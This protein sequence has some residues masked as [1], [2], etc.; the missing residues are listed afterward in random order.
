MNTSY[1][2]GGV[3]VSVINSTGLSVLLHLWA[4]S[5]LQTSV[6]LK[7]TSPR[8]ALYTLQKGEQMTLNGKNT[9]VIMLICSCCITVTGLELLAHLSVRRDHSEEKTGV[10]SARILK[11]QQSSPPERA[12]YS[13]DAE[14]GEQRLDL[15]V[16]WELKNFIPQSCKSC[17][18][19]SSDENRAHPVALVFV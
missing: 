18:Q 19:N 15:R 7:C 11:N 17:C 13:R 2:W 12:D 4:N 8:E 9:Q 3:I 6:A 10:F 1:T 5:I 14:L 16:T